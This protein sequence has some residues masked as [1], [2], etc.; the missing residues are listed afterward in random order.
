MDETFVRTAAYVVGAL[1]G[2]PLTAL[3]LRT[4]FF[5]GAANQKLET[6]ATALTTFC[7]MVQDHETRLSLVEDRQHS[8]R[9]L[10]SEGGR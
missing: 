8:P 4:V 10:R 2:L 5:L 3:L 6:I 9:Q 1:I 7:E